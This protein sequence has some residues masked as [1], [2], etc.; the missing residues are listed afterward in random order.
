MSAVDDAVAMLSQAGIA[1]INAV[2]GNNLPQELVDNLNETVVLITDAAN[3]PAAYGDNDF[4]ALNQE[5]EVQIW[6]SQ[7]LDSDPETIEIAMMKA[8]THQHWQV[9]AV[10]QR[11]LDQDT[12]QL[13][14]TF[15][16]SRTKNIGGI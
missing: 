4:W 6:Y 2:K 1:N 11:T 16:F 13:F 14:N 7:L 5:V 10:R 15:Y 9:A 8:F 3:D 12:Q